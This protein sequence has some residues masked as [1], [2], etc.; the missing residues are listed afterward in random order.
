MSGVEPLTSFDWTAKKPLAFRPFKPVYHITMAVQNSTPADLIVMDH[1]YKDRVLE[2]R[3]LMA[4]HP[5]IV[6][7]A[8]PQGRAS[9]EELYSSLLSEYL[10]RRFPTM[11]SLSDDGK[12]FLNRVTGASFPTLP[13]DDSV[14]ALKRLG[15]TVEDDMF[16]LHETEQSH[17]SVAYV[18]CYCSGFDPSQ[19]LD[20]LLPEIHKPVPSYDK[21]GPSMER[22]FRK[23]EVGKNVKRVNV[24][25]YARFSKLNVHR[26][27][28]LTCV[29]M[30]FRWQWSVVDSPILFNCKSNHVHEEDLGHVIKDDENVDISKVG[31]F[32]LLGQ[33]IADWMFTGSDTM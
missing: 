6:V 12:M 3:Q 17:R 7:G 2:R 14:Q 1:N 5:S 22:Y 19:K 26:I 23:L 21:I 29:L 4:Q 18:C 33:E 28:S 25:K 10:P 27:T 30:C 15:E 11:F 8:I 20:K 31:C 16:L 24:S 13:P 9:V 32:L